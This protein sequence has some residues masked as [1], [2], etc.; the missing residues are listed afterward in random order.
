MGSSYTNVWSEIIEILI[1][2]NKEKKSL[3]CIRYAFQAVLYVVWRERNRVR[4]GDK[5]LPLSV[6]K[7]MIDKG[8]R[9]KIS[10]LHRKGIKGMENMMQFWFSTRI[11]NC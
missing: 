5:V 1:D 7:R 8:I 3:V 2:R 10:V 6:M 11:P 4:H 9:N